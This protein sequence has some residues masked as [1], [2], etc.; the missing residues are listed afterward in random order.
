MMWSH[1]N[2]PQNPTLCRQNAEMRRQSPSVF[3][4]SKQLFSVRCVLR[5][6]CPCISSINSVSGL[7]C[8]L[9]FWRHGVEKNY[10][11]QQQIEQEAVQ[12]HCGCNAP[13]TKL[14]RTWPME[15]IDQW[16]TWPPWW[17]WRTW[18]PLVWM[19]NMNPP[20]EN[21]NVDSPPPR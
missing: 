9:R 21:R 16:R 14:W 4:Q 20:M 6:V 7:F 10:L 13:P 12:R 2:L 3:S 18:P 1:T 5:P 15:N 11:H 17:E 8:Q 19:E